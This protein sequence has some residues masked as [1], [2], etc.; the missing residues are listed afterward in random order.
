MLNEFFEVAIPPVVRRHGGTI[1]RLVGDAMMVTFNTRSDQP[2]H[3]ERAARAGLAIQAAAEAIVARNPDW[4]RFRVGINSG[5]ASV[6]ILGTSG[7]RTQTVIGDVVNTAAR[8]ESEAPVGGVA[9][10]AGTAERLIGAE[11]RTL[12]SISVEGKSEPV[13][14]FLLG[15]LADPG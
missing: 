14:A 5:Q 7:G 4:P 15:A 12:G 1:D 3:A 13:Q 10:G 8:L 11:L 2:D 9:V 6:S